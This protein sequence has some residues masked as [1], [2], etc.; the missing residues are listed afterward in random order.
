MVLTISPATAQAPPALSEVQRL[1]LQNVAQRIQ[2]AQL[3]AQAAQRA[4]EE[5]REELT[6]LV[7]SLKVEGWTLDLGTMGYVKEKPAK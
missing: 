6:A 3:Q 4:F 2:I 5:A 1:K 7:G